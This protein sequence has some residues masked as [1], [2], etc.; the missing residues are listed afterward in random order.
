MIE[1]LKQIVGE[2]SILENENMAS[3]TTFK[4]G[5]NASLYIAPN[6]TDELVK[7]LEVLRNENYPYMVIG[8]GS[9]LL[10]KDEGYDGAIVEV[11]KKISEIDVRGEEII[12]EAGAKLSKV[13]TI[14]MENDL[15]G[16]EFAHGI[17]GNMGGAVVMNAG[18]YGGEMKDVL[19]WVKVVDQNGEIKTL[20]NEELEL[21]YRTSRV[22]KEKMIV[23]EA[24]IKL[25]L[26]VM[27]DIAE[28]MALLMSKRKASQPLEY[29]SAGSTFKRPEGYFAGKLV[30]D[31]GMKGYRVGD[32]MVSDKHS[33]FVINCGN[34]TATEVIQVI[35]DVQ[36]KVK[37]DFGVD[38]EPEVRIIG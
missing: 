7:V 18:A 15:A 3:H 29:P 4:C 14:A 2:N 33:G 11:D 32:A 27:G 1:T 22:M 28:V 12:V 26:G 13:A 5:G 37:E 24:C 8:N 38:L 31:A 36:A 19:K 6:S 17:P 16:F 10:V 9:N 21:G 34:A 23:L 20:E 25:D 35:K 30:Q